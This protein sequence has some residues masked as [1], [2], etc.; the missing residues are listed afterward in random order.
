MFGSQ[1]APELADPVAQSREHQD[2][3]QFGAGSGAEGIE[4]G[5]ELLFEVIWTHQASVLC[6][7][8]PVEAVE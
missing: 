7:P 6:G 4:T 3:E 2:V 8:T 1:I 5:L